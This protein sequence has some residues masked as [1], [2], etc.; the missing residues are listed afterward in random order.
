LIVIVFDL[1]LSTKSTNQEVVSAMKG[2]RADGIKS[3]INASI[4]F[5]IGKFGVVL[6]QTRWYNKYALL[7]ANR[8][9]CSGISILKLY[10]GE[11]N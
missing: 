6:V 3:K 5:T 7:G 2:W 11:D 1:S 8:S 10:Q 9:Y 4:Y